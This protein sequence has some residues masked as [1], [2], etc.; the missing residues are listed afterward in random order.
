MNSRAKSSSSYVDFRTEGP[1]PL[2]NSK[3]Y[4]FGECVEFA[5]LSE[6]DD[7]D[8]PPSPDK[9]VTIS[10]TETFSESSVPQGCEVIEIDTNS[11]TKE[12]ISIHSSDSDSVNSVTEYQSDVEHLR[13]SPLLLD[14]ENISFQLRELYS[15]RSSFRFST[16]KDWI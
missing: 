4:S 1:V 5:R 16:T 13:D 2:K 11:S 7:Y 12:Y 9:A 15:R 8:Q 6:S 14:P 10:D 3:T